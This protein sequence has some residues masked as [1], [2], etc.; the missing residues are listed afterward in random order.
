[1]RF[2]VI[3][4]GCVVYSDFYIIYKELIDKDIFNENPPNIALVMNL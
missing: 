3:V 4:V 1:M 2:S